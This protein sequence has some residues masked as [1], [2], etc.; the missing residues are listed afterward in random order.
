MAIIESSIPIQ[1]AMKNVTMTVHITGLVKWK[2]QMWVATKLI[3][4]AARILNMN[5]EV[6]VNGMSR[7]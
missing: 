7:L 3:K 6:K 1:Y 5:I 4:L 2:F